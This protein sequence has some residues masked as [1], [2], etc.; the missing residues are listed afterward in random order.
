MTETLTR[1]ETD[2]ERGVEPATAAPHLFGPRGRHRRPRPR[3][4]L[5]AVGGLA[6]AA[7]VLS[8]VRMAPES[9]VGGPGTAEAG[10]HD[11][12]ATVGTDRATDTAATVSPSSTSVMG[13]VSATPTT[14]S[15]V[16]P[17]ATA[18]ASPSATRPGAVVTPRAP[19]TP[20][21]TTIPEAPNT[22]TPTP[23]APHASASA[24][25]TPQPSPSRSTP[26]PPTAQPPQPGLCVPLVG[27]CV[28]PL[29][30]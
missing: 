4:V 5:F 22:P 24:P 21:T 27:L 8:L 1:P 28:A 9:G 17:A 3:K 29:G 20:D 2:T 26:P 7:G 19:G 11:D 23:A 10:P 6:L 12:Q 18:T 14:T 30:H 15:T 13:G 16:V 25:A